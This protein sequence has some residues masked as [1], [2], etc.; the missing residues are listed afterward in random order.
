MVVEVRDSFRRVF[1]FV[2]REPACVFFRPVVSEPFDEVQESAPA[3]PVDLGVEDSF[4]FELEFAFD[5]DRGRRCGGA[6]RN[7]GWLVGLQ[8][9]DVEHRMDGTEGIG[10]FEG[11]GG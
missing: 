6:A 10:E 4:D 1:E 5:F 7:L 9:R 3:S 11:K 8:H 2:R